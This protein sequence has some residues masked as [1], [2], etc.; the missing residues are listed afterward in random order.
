V[1]ALGLDPGAAGTTAAAWR[2]GSVAAV[3][4]G[5]AGRGRPADLMTGTAV[6]SAVEAAAR[7]GPRPSA[8]VVCVPATWEPARAGEL[9]AAAV[10]A[11]VDAPSGLHAVPAPVA[12]AEL[13]L[14][15]GTAGDGDRILVCDAGAGEVRVTAV[16]ASWSGSRPLGVAV[17]D[18]PGGPPAASPPHDRSGTDGDAATG[19]AGAEGEGDGPPDPGSVVAAAIRG[20]RVVL[21]SLPD[22]PVSVLVLVG[23]LAGAPGL[24]SRLASQADVRVVV[25]EDPVEAVAE[26]AAWL[27]ARLAGL[28][29]PGA[30]PVSAPVGTSPP[31]TTAPGTTPLNI[32]VPGTAAVAGAASDPG[33]GDGAEDADPAGAANSDPSDPTPA[34]PA[35]SPEDGARRRRGAAVA[36]AAV[37]A[38]TLVAGGIAAVS[39]GGSPVA[40]APAR[41]VAADGPP[42]W[43]CVEQARLSDDQLSLRLV[44]RGSGSVGAEVVVFGAETAYPGDPGGTAIPLGRLDGENVVTVD[45]GDDAVAAPAR[46]AVLGGDRLCAQAAGVPLPHCVKLVRDRAPVTAPTSA[47]GATDDGPSSSVPTVEPSGGVVVVPVASAS[48]TTG[49]PGTRRTTSPPVGDDPPVRTTSAPA[50]VPPPAP[51]PTTR[52]P[53]TSRS[54][55]PPAVTTTTP[56]TTTPTTST[57]ASTEPSPSPTGGTSE[58][59]PTSP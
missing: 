6:W 33:P 3:P 2:D 1:V 59:S 9:L 16:D 32:A 55:S 42:P 52:P 39:L 58:P 14:R 27:G 5:A 35:A 49:A 40:G 38:L 29:P 50:P 18:V 4:L 11:G 36:A 57:S 45:L 23:G 26:G 48:R 13:A 20:L 34:L 22:V 10:A 54:S 19:S 17:V 15:T 12:V 43:V 47:P 24:R 46:A 51:Q 37:V 53:S 56:A 31:G 28:A 7:R 21:D 25:P 41:C 44:A 8:V 30:A